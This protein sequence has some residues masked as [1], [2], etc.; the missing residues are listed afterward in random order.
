[1]GDRV[2]QARLGLLAT[3]GR[4]VVGVA[5][6]ALLVLRAAEGAVVVASEACDGDAGWEPVPDRS[7]VTAT[8]DG[9]EL[10]AL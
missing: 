7:L 3:D 5:W 10:A 6:G 9:V 1:M 2:P 8:L 4:C